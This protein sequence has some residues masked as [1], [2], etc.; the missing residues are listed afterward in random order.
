MMMGMPGP[1]NEEREKMTKI[2]HEQPAVA[3]TSPEELTRIFDEL[4]K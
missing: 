1:S 2:A 4:S 3:N